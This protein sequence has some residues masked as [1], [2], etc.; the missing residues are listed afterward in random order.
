MV[1]EGSSDYDFWDVRAKLYKHNKY[2]QTVLT[3][4]FIKS[5][6]TVT[7]KL[8]PNDMNQYSCQIV[9]DSK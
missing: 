7:M 9:A 3:V 5:G 6:Q 8:D 1:H 4:L 2:N